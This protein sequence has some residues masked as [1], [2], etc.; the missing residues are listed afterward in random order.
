MGN[1]QRRST[2]VGLGLV[3]LLAL[4]A[5]PALARKGAR[6]EPP[7]PQRPDIVAKFTS[8]LI[9]FS[10]DDYSSSAQLAESTVS[11]STDD[12]FCVAAP[13]H[14]CRYSV[15]KVHLRARDF[16]LEGIAVEQLEAYNWYPALGAY[17]DGTG[18][19]LALPPGMIF[20]VTGVVDG[21]RI[22]FE[23]TPTEPNV[24]S[25]VIDPSHQQVMLMGSLSGSAHGH[26]L[27]LSLHAT[28]D[29]P[30]ANLPPQAAAG[31]DQIVSTSCYANVQLDKSGTTDPNGN[32]SHAYFTEHG[33]S[34]G[35]GA[36]PVA[37]F[38][39]VHHV[40][41]W[42]FDKMG[43]R[44]IDRVTID[45]RD[46]GTASPIPGASSY[47][48]TLPSGVLPEQVG[49][50]ATHQLAL[51]PNARLEGSALSFGP[52]R[53]EPHSTITGD[54]WASGEVDLRPGASIEGERLTA[55]PGGAFAWNTV[56]PGQPGPNVQAS[57]GQALDLAPGNYGDLDL[58]P[59]ATLTLHEG[60]YTMG[61]M[62]TKP[63]AIVQV[64]GS[65]G[66]MIYL[67]G[68]LRHQGEIASGTA[69][70]LFV[71]ASSADVS[72]VWEGSLLVPNGAATL[73]PPPNR[74]HRGAVFAADS[75][76]HASLVHAAFDWALL[77]EGR[78]ACAITPTLVCVRHESDGRTVARFSY[79]NAVRYESTTVPLGVA[80]RFTTA[81]ENRGQPEFFLAG[82]FN[83]ESTFEVP[84]EEETLTWVVG[85]RSATATRTSPVC[86]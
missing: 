76:L 78:S 12:P 8:G 69:E 10:A 44:S 36:E 13:D 27:S 56:L 31:P 21:E 22:V 47:S 64:D 33:F 26:T 40:E 86:P 81:P 67:R 38:P 42:A 11:L 29:A 70:R 35:S 52:V 18:L 79:E 23:V 80:N 60:T 71:A 57:P 25:M 51:R 45:V 2:A 74:Q 30:F 82:L 34:I 68:A 19:R 3:S 58:A 1:T 83:G 50:A 65:R 17:D 54:L 32:F 75:T 53:L 43:A 16:A 9:T 73:G 7:A 14:P 5:D 28:S 20:N 48:L 39:G 24:L 84:F 77:R 37:M 61:N 63:G 66:T 72:G 46:D 4:M 15:N 62:R 49:L 85:G 55:E 6:V 41:L 59:N